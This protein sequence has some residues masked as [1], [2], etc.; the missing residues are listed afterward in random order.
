LNAELPRDV[1]VLSC[2]RAADDFHVIRDA[3][4]KRYRY[5][6]DD[7]P[8]PDVLARRYA[9]YSPKPLDVAAMHRASRALVGRHDF[10]SY[11]TLGSQ[12]ITTVRTVLDIS[13]N[14]PESDRSGRLLVQQGPRDRRHAGSSG[15]RR[16]AGRLAGRSAG[17]LRSP[18]RRHDCAAARVVLAARRVCG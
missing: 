10:T 3:V 7:A 9:W 12:R 16:A 5:V 18:R 14:R 13:I 4:R 15:T 11:Q 8:V 2:E 6:I 1:A 17:S